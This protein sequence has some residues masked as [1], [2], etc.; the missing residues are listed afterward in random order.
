M[1]ICPTPFQYIIDSA[2]LSYPCLVY[3]C[4]VHHLP[5]SSTSL[6]VRISPTPIQYITTVRICPTPIQYII[7][8]RICPT[9]IQY[10]TDGVDLQPYSLEKAENLQISTKTPRYSSS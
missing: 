4:P 9:P 5:L 10:I 7:T 6:T 3:H 8:V 1:W 2:D